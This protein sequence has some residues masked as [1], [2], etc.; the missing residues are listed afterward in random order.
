VE[1]NGWIGGAGRRRVRNTNCWDVT[2]RNFDAKKA[3]EKM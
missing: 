2:K 1:H 3:S